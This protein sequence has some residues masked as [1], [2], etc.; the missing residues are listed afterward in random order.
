MNLIEFILNYFLRVFIS[1]ISYLS[2]LTYLFKIILTY[3]RLRHLCHLYRH[4]YHHYYLYHI[5]RFS[6]HSYLM[7]LGLYHQFAYLN[8]LL[9]FFNIHIHYLRH[10][11]N[12]IGSLYYDPLLFKKFLFIFNFSFYNFLYFIQ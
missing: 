6:L 7:F 4:I 5:Y 11:N 10:L 9:L 1:Y 2:Y 3:H 12:D 8:D